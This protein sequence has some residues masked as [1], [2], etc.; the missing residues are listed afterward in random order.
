VMGRFVRFDLR[1]LLADGYAPNGAAPEVVT[2]PADP[3]LTSGGYDLL[4]LGYP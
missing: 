4:R 3:L 1:T 2:V